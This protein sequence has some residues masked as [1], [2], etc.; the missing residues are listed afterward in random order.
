MHDAR[1]LVVIQAAEEGGYVAHAPDLPGCLTQGETLDETLANIRE[2]MALWLETERASGATIPP[3][4]SILAAWV[5]PARLDG[6]GVR[7]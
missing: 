6:D 4:A 1:Y 2:A 3:P 5:A 7:A